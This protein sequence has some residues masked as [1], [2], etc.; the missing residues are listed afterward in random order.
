MRSGAGS[1][2][3]VDCKVWEGS[4][5]LQAA[6]AGSQ[7]GSMAVLDERSETQAAIV[8]SQGGLDPL[9]LVKMQ[10]RELLETSANLSIEGKKGLSVET[11]RHSPN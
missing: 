9:L 11:G 1:D 6:A 5:C 7:E 2:P 3:S 10:R 8:S 4:S